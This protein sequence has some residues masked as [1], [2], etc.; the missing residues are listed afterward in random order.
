MIPLVSHLELADNIA[1]Y[2]LGLVVLLDLPTLRHV[3]GEPLR[4]KFQDFFGEFLHLFGHFIF[5]W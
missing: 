3:H 2:E 5:S 1:E 4:E